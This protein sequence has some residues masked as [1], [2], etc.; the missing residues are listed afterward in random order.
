MNEYTAILMRKIP[1]NDT[2][3]IF[4]AKKAITGTLVKENGKEYFLDEEG[5]KYCV[6]SDLNSAFEEYSVGFPIANDD[7]LLQAGTSNLKLA[8]HRYFEL[9]E[10]LLNIG[11]VMPQYT[12][13]AITSI[14][15]LDLYE[16]LYLLNF[17]DLNPNSIK[18][19][20]K[21]VLTDEELNELKWLPQYILFVIED[22]LMKLKLT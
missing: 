7:L 21:T 20:D 4:K 5:K 11:F 16:Q 6:M 18:K 8:Q 14:N 12:K 10:A 22:I 19:P 15:L 2:A 17:A 13:L 3:C 9:A 1:Y